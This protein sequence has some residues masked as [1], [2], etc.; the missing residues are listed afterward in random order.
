MSSVK[1]YG[2]H[3]VQQQEEKRDDS[4][5]DS[6]GDGTDVIANKRSPMVRKYNLGGDSGEDDDDESSSSDSESSVSD[7]SS[8]NDKK[9]QKSNKSTN[10]HQQQRGVT[11][12]NQPSDN[13]TSTK[14]GRGRPRKQQL[15]DGGKD[16]FKIDELGNIVMNKKRPGRPP[17][18]DKKSKIE[19]L[20]EPNNNN[21]NM[22]KRGRGRP[23]GAKSKN[24]KIKFSHPKQQQHHQGRADNSRDTRLPELDVALSA[25]HYQC[26]SATQSQDNISDIPFRRAMKIWYENTAEKFADILDLANTLDENEHNTLVFQRKILKNREQGF[27][28]QRQIV[29]HQRKLKQLLDERKRREISVEQIHN[30]ELLLNSLQPIDTQPV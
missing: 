7:E 30:L 9:K 18:L 5:E 19:E 11:K 6:N 13:T 1:K 4:D 15:D 2:K 27:L 29:E 23:P 28:L 12:P 22:K 3:R 26:E 10:V 8:D 24:K 17:K 14:R 21:N 20:N 25:L 16:D